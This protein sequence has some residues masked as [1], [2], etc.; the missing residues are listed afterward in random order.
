MDLTEDGRIGHH[1]PYELHRLSG[2]DGLGI[3][4]ARFPRLACCEGGCVYPAL[5]GG[6]VLLIILVIL[7]LASRA[8]HLGPRYLAGLAGV[9]TAIAGLV[10]AFKYFI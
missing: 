1:P 8:L 7:A 4:V 10:A 6:G 3:P 2:R 9:V 5:V